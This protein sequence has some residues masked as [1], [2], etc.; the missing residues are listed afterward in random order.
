M[1]EDQSRPIGI[2]NPGPCPEVDLGRGGGRSNMAK[3]CPAIYMG[4]R[5]HA[6]LGNFE[7]IH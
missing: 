7:Y 3:P 4:A 5:G 2:S 1:L 6:P